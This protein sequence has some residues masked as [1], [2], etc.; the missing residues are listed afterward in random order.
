MTQA[1]DMDKA[2][3]RLLKY[4]EEWEQHPEHFDNVNPFHLANFAIRN[5]DLIVRNEQ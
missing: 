5:K 3:E 1:I 2:S 4:A